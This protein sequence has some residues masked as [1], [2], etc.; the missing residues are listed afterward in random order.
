MLSAYQPWLGSCSYFVR[1][2]LIL[3][4]QCICHVIIKALVFQNV[5]LSCKILFQE[6]DG[7][8]YVISQCFLVPL[9]SK[10]CFAY[11]YFTWMFEL[12][13]AE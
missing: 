5:A 13:C 4:L 9:H 1:A 11:C 6:K 2:K 10:M 3:P 8:L 12:S 7:E